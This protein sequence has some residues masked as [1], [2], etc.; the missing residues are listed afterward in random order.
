MCLVIRSESSFITITHH[1]LCMYI[2][3]YICNIINPY[4]VVLGSI[5][6]YLVVTDFDSVL[7][8]V[9]RSMVIH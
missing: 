2:Y 1:G 4:M 6:E 9:F 5:I 3:I 7:R 8:Y